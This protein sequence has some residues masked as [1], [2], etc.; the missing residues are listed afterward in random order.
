MRERERKNE[1]GRGG[2]GGKHQFRAGEANISS[3]PAVE[4]TVLADA[5]PLNRRRA[6]A[7]FC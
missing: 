7:A 1:R 4:G 2:R 3:V 6:A 5:L